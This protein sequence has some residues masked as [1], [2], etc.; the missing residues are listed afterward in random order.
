MS[1]YPQITNITLKRGKIEIPLEPGFYTYKQDGQD[2]WLTIPTVPRPDMDGETFT[3]DAWDWGLDWIKEHAEYPE[4]RV[5]HIKGLVAGKADNLF[6]VGPFPVAEG[7]YLDSPLAKETQRVVGEGGMQTSLGFSVVEATGDCPT[8]GRGLI[9]GPLG[10]KYIFQCPNCDSMHLGKALKGLHFTKAIPFDV[11]VTDRPAVPWTVI[12]N[13]TKEAIMTRQE[14]IKRLVESGFKEE[15]V[16]PVVDALDEDQLGRFKEDE[17]AEQFKELIE[18]AKEGSSDEEDDKPRMISPD[19]A[20]AF[21]CFKCGARMRVRLGQNKEAPGEIVIEKEAMDALTNEVKKAIPDF[22]QF[23]IAVDLS[24]IETQF[25]ALADKLDEVEQLVSKMA[26][27]EEDRLAEINGGLSDASRSRLTL[28]YNTKAKEAEKPTPTDP[29]DVLI[30][31][32]EGYARS[33]SEY[34]G[35]GNVNEGGA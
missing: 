17:L 5:F 12:V 8:C 21:K 18:R 1:T 9:V 10:L 11:T 27:A 28:R 33:L 4:L 26:D 15:I 23:E 34:M 14:I 31:V 35:I 3:V 32:G 25:K 20:G 29:S 22:S 2:R 7:T 24:E 30:P 6:R 16:T 19:D 13:K